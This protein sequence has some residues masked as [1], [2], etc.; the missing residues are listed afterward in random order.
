[1]HIPFSCERIGCVRCCQ[2][3]A[4][5]QSSARVCKLQAARSSPDNVAY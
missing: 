2:Q 4:E 1:M 3:W 5:V